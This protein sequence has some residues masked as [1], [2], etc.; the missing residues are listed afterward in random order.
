MVKLHFNCMIFLKNGLLQTKIKVCLQEGFV[1]ALPS[2]ESTTTCQT[3]EVTWV[4]HSEILT[5]HPKVKGVFRK[6]P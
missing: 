3:F 2:T 6:V 5:T 1:N 4:K